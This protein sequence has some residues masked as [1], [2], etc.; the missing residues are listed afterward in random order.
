MCQNLVG[1]IGFLQKYC[2]F[3]V[4]LFLIHEDN[5]PHLQTEGLQYV[6]HNVQA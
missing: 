3:K 5:G 4:R 6:Y 2:D 1:L